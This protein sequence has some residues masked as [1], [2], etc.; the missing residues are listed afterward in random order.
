M[1][2]IVAPKGFYNKA[3]GECNIKLF[4]A[5]IVGLLQYANVFAI[6]IDFYASLILAGKVGAYLVGLPST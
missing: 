1:A 5:V 2:K 6:A 4:M 3:P